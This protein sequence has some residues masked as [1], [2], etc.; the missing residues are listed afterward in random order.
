MNSL[1]GEIMV[2]LK[3]MNRIGKIMEE[4]KTGSIKS[5]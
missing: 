4:V 3:K 5:E 2:I 1:D